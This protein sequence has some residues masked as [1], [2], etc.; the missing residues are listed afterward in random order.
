[1]KETYL[2][3][4]TINPKTGNQHSKFYRMKQIDT[5][6][7]ESTWGRIGAPGKS[8]TYNIDE[9][10]DI[11]DK[12]NAKG[13]T[14]CTE[15]VND[16]QSQLNPEIIAKLEKL[17]QRVEIRGVISDLPKAKALL[18]TYKR[19]RTLDKEAANILFV[20]YNTA[21]TKIRNDKVQKKAKEIQSKMEQK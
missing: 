16:F 2:E 1:M 10:W 7:F 21:N 20:K 12:K 19:M 8:K 14:E 15:N 17:I 3:N 4:R 18:N 13:Y 5:Y 9:W 11:L 6:T